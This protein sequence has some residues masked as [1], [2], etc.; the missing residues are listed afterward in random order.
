MIFH[1]SSNI[2]LVKAC[3]ELA[4]EYCALIDKNRKYLKK[5]VPWIDNVRD[6][7]SQK[8]YFS[9][10]NQDIFDKL[11][12]KYEDKIIG[13]IHLQHYDKDK[14]EI[15]IG[16]WIDEDYQ[17]R[18]IVK[19][20]AMVVLDYLFNELKI[21]RVNLYCNVENVKSENLAKALGFK[22]KLIDKNHDNLYGRWVDS[23]LYIL[24]R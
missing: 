12:I 10:V 15:E 3:P 23:K 7:E 13:E 18:G 4:S 22:F 17:G 14:N 11:L 21:G 5:T 2:S 1:I 9:T 19:K 24:I 8:K 20:S 16:Y 6:V